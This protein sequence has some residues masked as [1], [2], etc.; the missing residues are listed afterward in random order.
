MNCPKIKSGY[1]Y[2]KI[3]F[4]ADD[5]LKTMNTPVTYENLKQ[6]VD[7]NKQT[8]TSNRHMLL[9]IDIIN[10]I[11]FKNSINFLFE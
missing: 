11:S 5:M 10:I 4:L 6:L 2:D 1:P 3:E 7:Y 8:I 9:N